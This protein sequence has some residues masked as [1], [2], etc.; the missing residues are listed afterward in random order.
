[1]QAAAKQTSALDRGM[2]NAIKTGGAMA[3]GMK[4]LDMAIGSIRNHMGAAIDRFDT[5]QKFPKVMQQLGFGADEA[6]A[7][8]KKLGDGIDGLPTSLDE[9]AKSS[10]QIALITGDL[11]GAT[12][13]AI[14]LNNAFLASGSSAWDASRGLTQ[15]TQMLTTGKVDMQS[16]RTLLE[17][18][19]PALNKVAESFGYTG[20]SAKNDLYNAL[21]SGKITFD[22][23]NKRIIELND[24]VGGFAE[25]AKT[26]GTGIRTSF[27]NIGTAVTKGIANSITAIEE[28]SKSNGLGGI[29]E[30][31]DRVKGVV[32][33]AFE[34]INK[35]ISKIDVKGVVQVVSPAFKVL[36]SAVQTA[37]KVVIGVITFIGSHAGTIAKMAVPVLGL[38]AAFKGLQA[39]RSAV[40]FVK[41]FSSAMRGVTT[42][43]QGGTAAMKAQ[44]TAMTLMSAK[45]KIMAVT[46]NAVAVAQKV[47]NLAMKANP[48]ILIASLIITVVTAL[49]A[50]QAKGIDVAGA[51]TNFANTISQRID[52]VAKKMPQMI[53]KMITAIVNNLPKIIASGVKIIIALVNGVVKSIPKIV[54]AMPKIISAVVKGLANIGKSVAHCGAQ[55]V[56]GLWNGIGNK[57]GW[58]K[59]KISSFVG[60][61]KSWL[62]KFF[63]IGSPSKLMAKEVGQYLP[64]GI[65][66][67]FDDRA[68]VVK[69]SIKELSR[70]LAKQ[71]LS[72]PMLSPMGN[73]AYEGGTLSNTYSYGGGD[74]VLNIDGREFARA[75]GKY[76]EAE[77]NKRQMLN[78]RR[79]GIR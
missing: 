12:D 43:V 44:S 10:Q 31:A 51:I 47:L 23:F 42:V 67:G 74:V 5:L 52:A 16:W 36:G 57:V 32:N 72:M 70:D 22:D 25:L 40:T 3:L 66:K 33:T 55:V 77:Q 20:A 76:T 46:T 1:M 35:A 9:I 17:T 68:N 64:M 56:T 4:G 37:G 65:A 28:L 63:H 29:A 73:L 61:V 71:T 27:Q 2:G 30:N 59:S 11:D 75:T 54:A 53:T 45:Q 50:L 19:S 38:A 79:T 58:L 15:Y 13:T 21:K 60:N 6:E 26:Q 24:G 49:G 34:S 69:Q 7:A 48:F 8:I 62:K 78:N 14:A 18:M 39:A 41:T